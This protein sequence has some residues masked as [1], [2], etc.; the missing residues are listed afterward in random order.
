MK[1]YVSTCVSGLQTVASDALA[2]TLPHYRPLRICDGM[3]IYETDADPAVLTRPGVANNTYLLHG[4]FRDDLSGDINDSIRRNLRELRVDFDFIRRSGLLKKQKSFKLF[5]SDRNRPVR[6][7]YAL[8]QP[9]EKQI[10]SALHLRVDFRRPDAEFIFSRRSE[11]MLLFMTKITYNR[12]T[13]KDLPRGALRPELCRLLGEVAGVGAG[14]IVLDPFCGYGSIPVQIMKSFSYNMIFANDNNAAMVA[15][16][17]R[18]YGKND[19][20]LFIKC[21]DALDPANFQADFIDRI[22]TDPPWNVFHHTEESFAGFYTDML[23]EF[24]RILK[25]GGSATILM[26]N[27]PD[28][29]AAMAAVPGLVLQA[30]YNVLVNGK[31]ASVFK[32]GKEVKA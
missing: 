5:A 10:Q 24:E 9:L 4:A 23:R 16:L 1:R 15:A 28:F 8:T 21:R 26:G 17:K 31:K 30:R 18:T 13:E 6:L 7:D 11:G 19:R 22:I 29:E 14:D 25:P 32:L 2:R 12:L 27:L 20:R 3:V